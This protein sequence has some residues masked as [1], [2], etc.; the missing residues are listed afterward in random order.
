MFPY[1]E[2]KEKWDKLVDLLVKY[3]IYL[4]IIRIVKDTQS[5][6]G[7]P[8]SETGG[9]EQLDTVR[10]IIENETKFEFLGKQYV[11]RDVQAIQSAVTNPKGFLGETFLTSG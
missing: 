1:G 2:S 9:E 7:T 4:E 5:Q 11:F 6:Q 8:I 3:N 10:E